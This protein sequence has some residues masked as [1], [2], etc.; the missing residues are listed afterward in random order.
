MTF[1]DY[2]MDIQRL[3]YGHFKAV[4]WIFKDFCMNIQRLVI[5]LLYEHLKTACC[6][7]I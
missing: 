2:S 1:K 6:M 5:S 4:V 7:D 3:L